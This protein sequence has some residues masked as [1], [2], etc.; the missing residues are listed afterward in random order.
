[1]NHGNVRYSEETIAAIIV[2]LEMSCGMIYSL[3]HDQTEAGLSAY[4][5]I[6]ESNTTKYF[7]NVTENNLLEAILDFN[8]GI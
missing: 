6:D 8:E 2:A 5:G 3:N 1:M 7:I 4:A